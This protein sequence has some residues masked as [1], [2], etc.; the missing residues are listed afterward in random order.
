MVSA[1]TATYAASGTQTI[2]QFEL[3][4]RVGMGK[5][6]TVWK[7]QD[8]QLD[9]IVAVKI[10]RKEQLDEAETEQFL[11]EARAA[12]QVRHSNIVS[13]HEVG[14][15]GNL[16]YIVSDFVNGASL[17][18]WLTGQRLTPREA[19]ELCAK[20][21]DAL[22]AAHE[23]HVVHRDLKPGNIMLDLNGEPHLTDFGLAKRE[24]GEITMTVEGRI[25]GTPA[26]MSP[27]QAAGHGHTADRRSDVYSLGVILFQLLTGELPF[28][29]ESRMLIVQVI[30]D[31]PPRLRKLDSRIPRD[32]ETICGKCLR[33]EPNRRYQSAFDLAGDLRRWLNDQPIRARPTGTLEQ[34]WKWSGKNITTLAG[35]Y[36]IAESLLNFS[37]IPFLISG[38]FTEMS[39]AGPSILSIVLPLL[40]PPLLLGFFTLKGH[41]WVINIAFA[42]YGTKALF[43]LAILIAEQVLHLDASAFDIIDTLTSLFASVIGLTL[44]GRTLLLHDPNLVEQTV[45]TDSSKRFWHPAATAVFGVPAM[46]VFW[47][48]Y[49]LIVMTLSASNQGIGDLDSRSDEVLEGATEGTTVGITAMVRGESLDRPIYRMTDDAGGRFDVNAMTGEVSVASAS[50]LDFETESRHRITIEA[51]DEASGV[52]MGEFFIDVLDAAPLPPSDID[53]SPNQIPMNAAEGT[54]VGI[55]VASEEPNGPTS[56]L[57]LSDD[58]F[59]L[60]RIDSDRAVRTARR[61]S[62][63]ESQTRR[64]AV[65]ARAGSANESTSTFLID[66]SSATPCDNEIEPGQENKQATEDAEDEMTPRL[67]NGQLPRFRT[68]TAVMWSF[69]CVCYLALLIC[70]FQFTRGKTGVMRTFCLVLLAEVTFF[71]TITILTACFGCSEKFAETFFFAYFGVFWS[72]VFQVISLFP[73]WAPIVAVLSARRLKK[74]AEECRTCVLARIAIGFVGVSSMILAALGLYTLGAVVC[75]MNL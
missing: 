55:T 22:H 23:A 6:G 57:R 36:A 9:R 19:A 59:G 31:E 40:L 32:L 45:V 62:L 15:Q 1:E 18:D 41:R 4:E 37:S 51:G 65:S 42:W 29:G 25:L 64:I 20:I 72:F 60:F 73:I 66:I 34:L 44:F 46:A 2:A 39:G 58:A 70:G 3:I 10:P 38:L 24:A 61:L 75:R 12:A 69:D 21:A 14:R 5:F 47:A 43:W 30:K 63:S 8:T 52:V 74:E 7:A 54:Y 28:R 13:V 48:V 35:L 17:A 67:R 26:Y 49:F 50:L 11:R 53:E 68:I 27:E 16:V 56:T 71:I 33:K